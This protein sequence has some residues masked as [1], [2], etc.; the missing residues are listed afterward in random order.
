MLA[1]ALDKP[2]SIS[3]GE[4]AASLPKL[5]SLLRKTAQRR[6]AEPSFLLADPTSL[7]Q[8][9]KQLAKSRKNDPNLSDERE[10][11]SGWKSLF[12]KRLKRAAHIRK[13]DDYGC[14]PGFHCLKKRTDCQTKDFALVE[15]SPM[16]NV[17][18]LREANQQSSEFTQRKDKLQTTVQLI[19]MSYEYLKS[20][21]YSDRKIGQ[22]VKFH[23]RDNIDTRSVLLKSVDE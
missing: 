7:H 21:H 5:D 14:R 18:R 11:L 23:C 15:P 17:A 4:H 2:R 20:L 12:S 10:L 8:L 3:E 16:L 22:I 1:K 9:K 19:L 6:H 13:F